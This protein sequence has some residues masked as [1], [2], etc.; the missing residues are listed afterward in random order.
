MLKKKTLKIGVG[1]I[2]EIEFI[3]QMFQ[4]TYGG[5]NSALRVQSTIEGLQQLSNIKNYF[6]LNGLAI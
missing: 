2:R 4:L 5:K 3:T 6:H 1:G